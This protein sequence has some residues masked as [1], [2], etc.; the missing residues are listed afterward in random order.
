MSQAVRY[1]LT[2]RI[3][4]PPLQ[5]FAVLI[6]LIAWINYINFSIARSSEN[7][8]EISIRK[9]SGSSRLQL[10]VQLLV[11]S[12]LINLFAV[13]ISLAVIQATLPILKGGR[14]QARSLLSQWTPLERSSSSLILCQV[15]PLV[16]GSQTLKD[17]HFKGCRSAP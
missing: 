3:A 12:A 2:L 8:K 16:A 4:A 6:L 9:I 14:F 11:D 17:G 7:S 10:M 5:I 15:P 1:K 13:L